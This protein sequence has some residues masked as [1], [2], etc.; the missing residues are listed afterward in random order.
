MNDEQ[1][2]LPEQA[3]ENLDKIK[4]DLDPEN[5]ILIGWSK[6]HDKHYTHVVYSREFLDETLMEAYG[7][8]E[9]FAELKKLT[10]DLSKLV[11]SVA[12]GKAREAELENNRMPGSLTDLLKIN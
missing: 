3:E 10:S 5:L 9:L 4:G 8:G 2:N 1:T 12:H 11:V 7:D 6:D